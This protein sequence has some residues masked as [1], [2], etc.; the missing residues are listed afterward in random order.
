ML[1]QSLIK[2][3]IMKNSVSIKKR[4][5]QNYDAFRTRWKHNQNHK[6]MVVYHTLRSSLISLLPDA[7]I[8]A[9]QGIKNE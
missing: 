3:R 7:V 4:W 1:E 6:I 2:R 5:R 8:A 9:K